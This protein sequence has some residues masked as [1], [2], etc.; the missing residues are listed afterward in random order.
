MDR[1]QEIVGVLD[2]LK[3][4][5]KHMPPPMSQQLVTEFGRDPFV[6]LVSCILSL[7]TKDTLTLPLSRAL[8][9]TMRTPDQLLAL[10]LSELEKRIYPVGF[11]RRK[12]LQ[13]HALCRMLKQQFNACVPS[14]E[15][16]LLSLPG[17]GVKTAALVRSEGFGIPD[18]C[19]DTHVHRIA[20]RLGWIQTKTPEK[21]QKELKKL[22]PQDRWI[23]V[24]R[25]LVMWGQNQCVP[26]S[27]WCA[28]C[29]VNNRCQRQG[30]KKSR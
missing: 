4:A 25:V 24:N 11:Y 30:V 23:D 27:P 2:E 9:S 13:I 12:A 19:V 28:T 20:N 7:R 18:I 1:L 6:I 15:S 21:S 22:M 8:F 26:V 17:V 10:T 29:P 16:D 3:N 14:A 5:T